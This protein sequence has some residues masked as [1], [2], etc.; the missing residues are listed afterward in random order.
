MDPIFAVRYYSRIGHI[1]RDVGEDRKNTLSFPAQSYACRYLPPGTD[2][3]TSRVEFSV[4]LIYPRYIKIYPGGPTVKWSQ[5]GAALMFLSHTP[6]LHIL[7]RP[8]YHTNTRPTSYV[9][10]FA[11]PR[12]GH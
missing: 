3:V 12:R 8:F 2:I 7:P 5:I 1:Y 11:E 6:S 9:S 10:W 4:I